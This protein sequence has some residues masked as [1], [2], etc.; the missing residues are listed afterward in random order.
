ETLGVGVV[1]PAIALLMQ[2]DLSIKYP[3]ITPLLHLLGDPS[4]GRLVVIGMVSLTGV[5]LVKTI[6]LAFLLW[7]QTRFSF[8]V[9]ANLSHRLFK[10][11]LRQPYAF[12]LQ[13]NSAQLIRN[14]IT[15]V[16]Q[17]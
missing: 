6:F 15:E 16:N 11:Y 14:A 4:P 10:T 17:F 9:Q 2:R 8:D 1:I 7:R 5:Y 3:A 13:R 12:H